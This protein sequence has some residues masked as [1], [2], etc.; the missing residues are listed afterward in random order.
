MLSCDG[1]HDLQSCVRIS[2]VSMW[3]VLF[4]DMFFV[5][6]QVMQYE[7][8]IEK[9]KL[10]NGALSDALTKN[11]NELMRNEEQIQSMQLEL[12]VTQEKH[13]TCQLEVCN[14]KKWDIFSISWP[15]HSQWLY[16]DPK[17]QLKFKPFQKI[18]E[19]SVFFSMEI[20]IGLVIWLQENTAL[21]NIFL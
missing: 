7:D 5:C 2:V 20:I 8:E 10:E 6:L 13:R 3:K 15:L 11:A 21:V 4:Y 18:P 14:W 9:V 1:T 12:T 17:P 19:V 16:W